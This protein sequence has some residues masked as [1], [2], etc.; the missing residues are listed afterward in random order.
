MSISLITF[1]T[2]VQW[3]HDFIIKDNGQMHTLFAR[4][5]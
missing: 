4:L 1:D 2:N 5:H 3:I